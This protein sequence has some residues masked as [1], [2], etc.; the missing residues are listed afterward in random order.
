MDMNEKLAKL[1]KAKGLTQKELAETLHVSRQAISR[2]E[3]GTAAPSLDNLAY[4]SQL[5]GV[6]LD[7]LVNGENIVSETVETAPPHVPEN[8][9]LPPVPASASIVRPRIPLIPLLLA[10]LILGVGILIGISLRKPKEEIYLYPSNPGA[11]ITVGHLEGWLEKTPADIEAEKEY[12][13][14]D[15]QKEYLGSG[16]QTKDYYSIYYPDSGL[17]KTLPNDS[18]E[19]TPTMP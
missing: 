1:R 16:G 11:G 6:P 10:G 4:L 14:S 9:E 3:V 15:G 5:Y 12:L 8:L 17:L 7:D 18:S 19:K 13:E 2:W